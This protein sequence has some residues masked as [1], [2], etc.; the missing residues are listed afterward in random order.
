MRVTV[1]HWAWYPLKHIITEWRSKLSP[2]KA[3]LISYFEQ[4]PSTVVGSTSLIT[5]TSDNV[6]FFNPTYQGKR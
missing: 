6:V 3:I 4:D 5:R 1:L 2:I